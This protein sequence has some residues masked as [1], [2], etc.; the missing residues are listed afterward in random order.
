MRLNKKYI[1]V[2]LFL[3][4]VYL[5]TRVFA[6]ENNIVGIHLA[7]PHY[8]ELVAASKLVNGNG[9]DWGY[10]TLVIQEND[11]DKDKWQ[12]IFNSL[13]RL[14]MIPLVRLATKP[15]GSVWERP[16]K[17]D[18]VEWAHFLN[19]L[20]WPVK[21]RY[22][23]LF[24]EPNHANEWGGSVD[25]ID[26]GNVASEF[27]KTL[28]KENSDFLI[29]LAGFDAAAPSSPPQYEDEYYFLKT[30][31]THHP[32]L[33]TD[34]DAWS[35]HS[36]PNPEFS[37]SPYKKGR[38]S[39]STYDWE[40]SVLREFGVEKELPVFI[41]ETGWE[42][43]RVKNYEQRVMNEYNEEEYRIAENFKYAFEEVWGKD[44]R[45]K[46]VTP[47]VLDYQADPFL[48]FSWK[49]QGSETYYKQFETIEN[50]PK[51]KGE[52][53]QYEKMSISTVM[54]KALTELSSYVFNLSIANEGQAVWDQKW[55]YHIDVKNSEGNLPFMYFTS[56]FSD[57]DPSEKTI[58]KLHVKTQAMTGIF[59][60]A[61]DLYK[62][63]S[64]VLDGIVWNVEIVPQPSLKIVASSFP[65]LKTSGRDFEIQIFN[66]EE[67]LVYKKQNIEFENG[68][69]IAEQISDITLGEQYRMV[70]LRPYYLPRQTYLV[71]E[72]GE[73]TV[74]FKPLL[75]FDFNVDGKLS[76]SDI[77]GLLKNMRLLR[78]LIP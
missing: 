66:S 34:I 69:G 6:S 45:V 46:A 50:I 10:V 53:F 62:E 74:S 28:K 58:I 68:K 78:M 4:V 25:A 7:Q 29:M 57:V 3:L 54:P 18:A 71:F 59:S 17:E 16:S 39:I 42:Q 19:S 20:L 30:L 67:K 31:I 60:I 61:I 15:D 12:G 64:K 24:N 41:T 8:E 14:H 55:G 76:F 48:G 23:I 35:S 5:P 51:K 21:D 11:R 26:Y 77:F 13:R 27:A 1:F 56:D 47:F 36:Y 2:L 33:M 9:G 37:A 32:R 65:K 38:N 52:P 49:R 22:I 70:L 72:K 75:P 40:L 43:K 44:E 63:N 73:N